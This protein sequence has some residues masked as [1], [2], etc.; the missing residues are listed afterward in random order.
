M[1]EPTSFFIEHRNLANYMS[2][3][4]SKRPVPQNFRSEMQAEFL[5]CHLITTSTK[6]VTSI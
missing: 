4:G 3:L 2:G 5:T 1:K 6:D